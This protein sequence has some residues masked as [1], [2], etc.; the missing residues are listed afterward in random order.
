MIGRY[1]IPGE[2][3]AGGDSKMRKKNDLA[4][5]EGG[6]VG[7]ETFV[8]LSVDFYYIYSSGGTSLRLNI[9][10]RCKILRMNISEEIVCGTVGIEL[11]MGKL[12]GLT[13]RGK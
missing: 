3:E 12:W 4:K 5:A 1:L 11:I 8:F 2:N 10:G 13:E 7:S 9:P 6:N